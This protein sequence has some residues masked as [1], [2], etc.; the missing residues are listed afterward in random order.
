[1]KT[2]LH[3]KAVSRLLKALVFSLTIFGLANT[4]QA[5]VVNWLPYFPSVS[6]SIAI[7]YNAAE[8]N[9]GVLGLDTVYIHTGLVT[10]SAT[11]TGWT[12]VQGVWGTRDRRVRMRPLGNNLHYIK[13]GI[14]QFYNYP[15]G[16]AFR[17][18]MVFRNFDGSRVGRSSA[19]TDIFVPLYQAGQIAVRFVQ[20]S[21]TVVNVEQG[22]PVPI[23]L[24]S[25][26]SANL[27]ITSNGNLVAVNNGTSIMQ[28]VT[29]NT[30]G[31]AWVKAEAEL[32]GPVLAKDSFRV[33]V[34]KTQ[35]I[36]DIPAGVE[37]GITYLPNGTSAILALY[38]P[39]KQYVYCLGD[40]NNFDLNN[41]Y[42][43][44]RSQ[45]GNSYWIQL[46]N[47]PNTEVAF[48]YFVDGSIRI[49]DPY[50]DIVLDPN[51][52][53]F[54]PRSTYAGLRTYPARA[55]GMVSILQCNQQP[56]NW[57]NPNF[58]KPAK[59]DLVV[60]EL[61]VRDFTS[62]RNYQRLTDSLKYLKRLGINCIEIMPV[63]E[64]DGNISWGYNPSY[65]NAIDKAYGSRN[66]FKAFV[67]ACHGYGIAVVVD[68]VF[69]HGTGQNPMAALYWNSATNKPAANSPYFNQDARHPFNVYNDF[70][71][72]STATQYYMD[73]VN[74]HFLT[75][76]RVDGF[77]FDLSKGF[78]QVNSG[79]NV[80]AWSA[81]DASRV[82]LLQRMA[83]KIWQ[84]SP[85]AYVILEHLA[86]NSEETVLANYG[87][88]L[89]GNINGAYQEATEGNTAGSDISWGFYRN[90]GWQQPN[91]LSYMESHDEERLMVNARNNGVLFN[92]NHNP[93]NTDIALHRMKLA[94]TFF[95]T[96][97]GPKMIW[98]FGEMG[99]DFS[100]NYCPNGTV[101]GNCRT[102]SKPIRWDYLQ[103]ANRR[104]LWKAYQA[105]IK[106]KNEEPIFQNS[107]PVLSLGGT[108]YK[109]IKN[110]LNGQH[111][112]VVGNFAV[113]N[114]NLV[115][116]F[117]QTGK[118]YEFFTGDSIT[119][120][121]VNMQ[122]AMTPSEFRIYSTKKFFTPDRSILTALDPELG[123]VG[124]G[125][126]VL[127]YP[128]PSNGVIN[129]RIPVTEAG[130]VSFRVYDMMGKEVY[131]QT[132]G[133]QPVGTHSTTWTGL[134]QLGQPVPNGQ[135]MIR[136]QT[137]N[138]VKTT[139]V[140][141]GS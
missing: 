71:H 90:R 46:D 138:K 37:Y 53:Q 80:G 82:R 9:A 88:M 127:A 24:R 57:I 75:E 126:E 81:Y 112:V 116:S 17:L 102:D 69:N 98:Q 74:K 67:D 58:T 130:Q 140:T 137:G 30:P 1:M 132:D 79:S 51:N 12:N 77:R 14:R 89:W 73:R 23:E 63:N 52:D 10:T 56:Y 33:F 19:G 22:Q 96:I 27:S 45:D 4:T 117:Q 93:R 97:P 87:M 128:N 91:L 25:S 100:I 26:I 120:T 107:T 125:G 44:N 106:L 28:S 104:N 115:P 94:S 124:N 62:D 55:Q 60:Y 47:L 86:D 21:Q 54:I 2:Y 43:M 38:A 122:L 133:V 99:Y 72:E 35:P 84:T 134:S 31:Y 11:A 49:G 129:I 5:Q 123:I 85:N 13:I 83:D 32:G 59:T 34:R 18:G 92:P 131:G 68:M 114:N 8:G 78:T 113:S 15:A 118:W 136:I 121:N 7:T 139:R 36:Q 110:T 50:S 135:Y 48:Q 76:Y 66:N 101:N 39:L 41:D 42:L 64:F 3:H 61:L 29:F 103:D 141:V 95:F 109:F 70:N 111:V 16:N 6:D 40:F 108:S 65:H 20:P 119:V 105:L